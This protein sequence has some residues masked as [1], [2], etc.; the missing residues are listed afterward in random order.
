MRAYNY[1]AAML[2]A[3]LLVV[4]CDPRST[5]F[6]IATA[7]AATMDTIDNTNNIE[8]NL[9]I[10]RFNEEHVLRGNQ[11]YYDL[12]LEPSKVGNITV[13]LNSTQSGPIT[14]APGG[15][16][17]FNIV[18]KIYISNA[19]QPGKHA[20]LLIND[21][22]VVNNNPTNPLTIGN[23][24][25]RFGMRVGQLFYQNYFNIAAASPGVDTI[26]V[27]ST[28]NGFLIKHCI[29]TS[30]MTDYRDIAQIYAFDNNASTF[31]MLSG[32]NGT[33][34]ID[35]VFIPPGWD[36]HLSYAGG[37]GPVFGN[38]GLYVS[39]IYDVL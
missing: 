3:V 35:D 1:G 34:M 2:L 4:G 12:G 7:S 6:P 26:I 31:I 27:A 23:S 21:G 24:S 28:Q 30:T 13:R 33:S 32:K 10:A 16:I 36:V 20:T 14:L 17:T 38:V 15:S 8:L 22:A 9:S 11:V 25:N 18:A 29:L 37:I 19:A 39:I 5:K